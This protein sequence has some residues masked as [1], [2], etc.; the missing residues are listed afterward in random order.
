M[1]DT[2][3]TNELEEPGAERRKDNLSNDRPNFVEPDEED[4]R[5][6]L[7]RP[8]VPNNVE[9]L[10]RNEVRRELVM[11]RQEM[12]AEFH[13]G[14]LPDPKTFEGYEHIVPGSAKMIFD[15]FR[16]QGQHRMRMES[17]AL[18]WGNYRS[19]AGLACGFVIAMSFLW[20]SYQLIQDGHDVAGT[21]LATVDLVALVGVFIYGSQALRNERVRKAEVMAGQDKPPEAPAPGQL[22]EGT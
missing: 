22:E 5:D 13:S 4:E 16:E 12:R 6:P 15:N 7:I 10:L 14:P 2:P 1:A 18:R 9:Q 20:A 17:Y 3:E 11:V 8:R 19:F 21:I